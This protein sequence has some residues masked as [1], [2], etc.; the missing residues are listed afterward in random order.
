MDIDVLTNLGPKNKNLLNKLNIYTLND[1]LT[2]YPYRYNFITIKNINE[3]LDEVVYINAIVLSDI[4]VNYIRKNFNILSFIASNNNI[5]FKV[6]IYNRAFLKNA[7]YL[8]REILL[9]GK[10][11]KINNTF[12]ASDIKFNIFNNK[13]EAVYHL[14]EGLKL[15]N[16]EKY[17]L[18]AIDKNIKIDDYIPNYLLEKYHFI[19]K[20][21]ALKYIHFPHD[22]KEIKQAKLRLIYEELFIYTFKLNYLA[23]LN[24]RAKGLKKDFLVEDIDDFISSLPFKLTSDQLKT[25]NDIINDLKKEN[26]MNRLIL[27]DVGSG[28]TIVAVVAI[29]ANYL[30]GY[31]ATF[32]APT[33][34]LA[35]Q[36]YEALTN[37]F[38]NYDLKVALLT[39]SMRKKEKEN[40]YEKIKKK[41]IDVVIG[42]HAL[43]NE[44]LNFASLGLVITDEQHRFGVNQRNI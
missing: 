13:I 16:L 10:Y 33:E 6:T 9:I 11:K 30:S 23:M 41:E 3:A 21:I 37:Y 27:G 7:L 22:I 14:T 36:H 18:E 28:K 38:H 44:S 19:S 34:I 17:M 43:L 15:A 25:I 4:K 31:Q 42:T 24:K 39:G 20:D 40:L 35:R 8:N 32:M 1:L 2:Y 26:R 12:I 5:N 29:L